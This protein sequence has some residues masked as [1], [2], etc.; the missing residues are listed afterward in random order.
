MEKE[1][2]AL[3]DR[4][5]L[6]SASDVLSGGKRILFVRSGDQFRKLRKYVYPITLLRIMGKL[7]LFQSLTITVACKHREGL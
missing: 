4:P 2:S 7:I 1:N 5:P 6:I 3:V